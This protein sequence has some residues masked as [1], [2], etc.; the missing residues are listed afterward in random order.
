M[1]LIYWVDEWKKPS[2][3]N[4][5]NVQTHTMLLLLCRVKVY[6][7]SSSRLG[8]S[9]HVL[10]LSPLCRSNLEKKISEKWEN[11]KTWLCHKPREKESQNSTTTTVMSLIVMLQACQTKQPKGQVYFL[12]SLNTPY[13]R[14]VESVNAY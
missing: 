2:V 13:K 9:C 5:I 1:L 11:N 10:Q 14:N 6:S 8:L 3:F 12:F 4:L 7:L